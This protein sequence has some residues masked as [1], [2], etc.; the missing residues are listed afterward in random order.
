M[1]GGRGLRDRFRLHRSSNRLSLLLRVFEL[2]KRA[3]C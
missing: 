3:T 1:H 2:W